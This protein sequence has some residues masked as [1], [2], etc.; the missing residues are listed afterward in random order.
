MRCTR[1]LA[2]RHRALGALLLVSMLGAAVAAAACSSSESDAHNELESD[3]AVSN[4]ND[5]TTSSDVTDATAA[6]DASDAELFDGGAPLAVTC[7]QQPCAHALTGATRS[8]GTF[9]VLLDQGK[10][11]CWGRNGFYDLGRGADA[12]M[13]QSPVPQEVVGIENAIAIEETCAILQGGAVKCWG[14]GNFL[15]P[16][17]PFNPMYPEPVTLPIPPVRSLSIDAFSKVGCAVLLTGEMSCW[18]FVAPYRVDGGGTIYDSDGKQ[19]ERFPL[20]GGFDPVEVKVGEA[21][22]VRDAKGAVLSWGS[23]ASLGRISSLKVDPDALPIT[24]TG[25]TAMDAAANAAC[26]ITQGKVYCWGSSSD[27]NATNNVPLHALPEL[28]ALPAPAIAVSVGSILGVAAHPFACAVTANHELYCWGDNSRGQIGDGTI[29]NI[30]YFPVKV[31]LPGRVV[32]VS[33]LMYD[34]CALLESGQV[35]CWGDNTQ[36][37]LGRGTL[38]KGKPTPGLV[39]F[40]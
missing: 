2:D 23:R 7:A 31:D 29:G 39:V 32:S 5:A 9:C 34:A 13:T 10:V 40:P 33:T 27:Y 24:L 22:F 6:N 17:P 3:A 11:A 8:S 20:P 14:P 30:A 28:V 15:Q 36:G 12:G 4:S 37:E 35:Y 26:A 19:L 38:G 1:P 16:D 21:S 18:G 25:I